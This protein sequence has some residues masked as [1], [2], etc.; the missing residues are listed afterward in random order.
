MHPT[1][2]TLPEDTRTQVIELL[3]GRLVDVSDLYFQAK[4]AHWNVKGANFIALHKLFDKVAECAAEWTD[5]IAERIVQ[6]G[7]TAEGTVQVVA[8]RS[9]LEEYP[10]SI[11][12]E[13]DHIHAISSVL[14]R[15]GELVREGID[16]TEELGD[17]GTSDLLID[18]VR[19]IDKLLW[20]VEAH[21]GEEHFAH[22]HGTKRG[23]TRAHA[24]RR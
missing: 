6:L 19:D 14:A 11:V 5:L 13:H 1:H 12:D 16:K 20:F 2:N 10:T 15:C 17:M 18:V 4:T 8:E 24:H 3:A 7:G 21:L 23:V 9:N 22:A